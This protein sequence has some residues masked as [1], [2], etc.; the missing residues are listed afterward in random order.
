MF[1]INSEIEKIIVLKI[2]MIPKQ[3]IIFL[4]SV[5]KKKAKM[6]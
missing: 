1:T 3:N 4:F 6:L 2:S 5:P